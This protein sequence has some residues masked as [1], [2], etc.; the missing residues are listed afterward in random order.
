MSDVKLDLSRLRIDNKS[1]QTNLSSARAREMHL[2]STSG[3]IE[4]GLLQAY[5]IRLEPTSGQITCDELNGEVEYT[6]TSGDLVVRAASGAGSYR[7]DNSGALQVHYQNLDGDLSLYNKSED[8]LLSLPPDAAFTFEAKSKNGALSTDFPEA[9]R[10]EGGKAYGVV[11]RNPS[12][13]V[14]LETKDGD[15]AV[16]RR[17]R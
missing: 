10:I 1:G 14:Y 15:I 4:G 17:G 5:S 6:T 3:R 9:L 7:A 11:G 16:R 12:A 2:S 13:K 8:I